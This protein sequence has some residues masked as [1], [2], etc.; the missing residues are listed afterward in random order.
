MKAKKNSPFWQKRVHVLLYTVHRH[1]GSVLIDVLIAGAGEER[2]K[3]EA[4]HCP[5]CWTLWPHATPTISPASGGLSV[6]P[7][8][9]PVG[10]EGGGSL[11][12]LR[13]KSLSSTHMSL[14]T[15]KAELV[16]KLKLVG[17]SVPHEPSG[18]I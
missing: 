12:G 14:S 3:N 10:A 15:E 11:G 13:L 2:R 5:V 8:S 17:K 7:V 6:M 9:V 1:Q 16:E 18:C 4:V